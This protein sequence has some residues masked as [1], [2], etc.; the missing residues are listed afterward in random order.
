MRILITGATGFVGAS[1]TRRLSASGHDVITVSRK[2]TDVPGAAGNIVWDIEDAYIL[3]ALPS[4]LDAIVHAAQSRNYRNFPGD[5]DEMWRV[6]VA[7]TAPLLN[8]AVASGVRHFCLISSGAVYDPYAGLLEEGA[9]LAPS[10]FLGATKLAAEVLARPYASKLSLSILRLFFPYGPGQT[11]R[12]TPNIIGRV[13]SGTPVQ[14]GNDGEG[15]RFTPT[16]I[17]DISH[18]IERALEE[19]WTGVYNVASD[20]QVSIA[21]LAFAIGEI[22]NKQP[23]FEKTDQVSDNIIPSLAKLQGRIDLSNFTHLREGLRQMLHAQAT[24]V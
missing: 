2:P 13:R 1:L 6:N 7:P 19:N 20:E 4:D 12:L 16:Y 21:G 24:R 11:N 14:V 8:F 3:P 5:A 23:V 17:E 15:L 18:V 10:G 22:I 9:A